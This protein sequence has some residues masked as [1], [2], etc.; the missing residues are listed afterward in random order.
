MTA[1][2]RAVL[3]AVNK[4]AGDGRRAP[5]VSHLCAELKRLALLPEIVDSLEEL[6]V[7]T[8]ELQQGGQLR[9]IVAAGGDGTVAEIA[10]RT[11]PETPI[12]V[13]PLGTENLLASY[14]RIKAD[15]QAMASIIAQGRTALFDAG[16][17]NGRLFLLM[18]SVGFDAEVVRKVHAV[19]NGHVSRWSYLKPILETIRTYEYPELRVAGI[20]SD[21][22]R[23]GP[24]HSRFAFVFNLPRY[25]AGLKFAPMADGT[26]GML[27]LCTFRHGGLLS[28]LKYL[29]AVV[30]GRH[31]ESA[32]FVGWSGP[33]LQIEADRPVP[34]EL[35]GDPGGL[36]PLTINVVPRRMRFVVSSAWRPE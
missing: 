3:I 24:I 5:A 16:Q 4:T 28:G 35:D 8:A 14:L 23:F 12:A 13:F 11:V 34:Y 30:R 33:R 29:A 15:P 7:R 32:D 1:D 17:A 31:R 20:G 10:N 36:L 2:S 21:S 25:A 27:D 26:D 22:A 19:R 18:A 9:S 6:S